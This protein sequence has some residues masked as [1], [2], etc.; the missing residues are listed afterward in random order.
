MIDKLERSRELVETDEQRQA[1]D[2]LIREL[3]SYPQ[4]APATRR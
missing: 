2:D 4:T 3:R 1:V